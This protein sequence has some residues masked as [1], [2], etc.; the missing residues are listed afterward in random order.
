M[1]LLKNEELT[2][3]KVPA[4]SF[5]SSMREISFNGRL[6]D[7]GSYEVEGD[8]VK[9]TVWHDEEEESVQSEM[10]NSV[11]LSIQGA[12]KDT[13]ASFSSYHPFS[14][15]G[16]ILHELPL[17][18]IFNVPVASAYTAGY[19]VPPSSPTFPDVIKPPP[20]KFA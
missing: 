19:S 12:D 1:H 3:I 10:V 8:T 7:V 2:I 11:E 4:A 15:D 5:Y 9:V 20:D 14:P 6:Y 16:K 17:L 18:S 13:S